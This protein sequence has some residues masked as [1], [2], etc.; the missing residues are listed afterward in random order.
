MRTLFNVFLI[1]WFFVAAL[2]CSS[3][4]ATSKNDS[5]LKNTYAEI[6]KP[7][8]LKFITR[9]KEKLPKESPWQIEVSNL[10]KSDVTVRLYYYKMP[11]GIGEVKRDA[12]LVAKKILDI[13][14]EDGVKPT[15]DW[16]SVFVHA[17][18]KIDEKSV[19]GQDQL[20]SFGSTSYD[21]NEDKLVWEP[22]K[23]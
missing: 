16:A 11:K 4:E 9:L 12:S 23:K 15:E 18:K 14:I 3:K 7:D 21:F 6:Q 17:Y 13:L 1:C 19:T 20:L 22:F 2:S 8:S 5:G 10:E